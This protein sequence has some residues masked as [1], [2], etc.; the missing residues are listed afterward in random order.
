MSP[1]NRLLHHLRGQQLKAL[2]RIVGELQPQDAEAVRRFLFIVGPQYDMLALSD[3]ALEEIDIISGR[4]F[5]KV[6]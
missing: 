2:A 5:D 3:Y 1:A 4:Y 6:G